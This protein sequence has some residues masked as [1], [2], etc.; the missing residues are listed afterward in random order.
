[1]SGI[2]GFLE[3]LGTVQRD[4]VTR[5]EG[6]VASIC[7]DAYGC[8]QAYVTPPVGKDGKIQDGAWFDVKRLEDRGKRLM[9]PVTF[10]VAAR[11][12]SQRGPQ[13]KPAPPGV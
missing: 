9:P 12:E 7:F 1:M 8:V 10:G 13:Q 6:M 2:G 3:L 11:P 5:F 4:R